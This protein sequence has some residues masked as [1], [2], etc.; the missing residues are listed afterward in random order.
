M[1]RKITIEENVLDKAIKWVAPVRAAR[2]FHARAMLALAGG[3]V[4]GSRTRRSLSTFTPHGTSADAALLPDLPDLR[5]RSRDLYRNSPLAGGAIKTNVTS[6]A[7]DGLTMKCAIDREYL[8]LSDDAAEQW[9]KD[10]ERLWCLWSE[11]KECDT[12]RTQP[13]G[14]MQGLVLGST[15]KNGDVF[16]VLPM[17]TPPR[18]AV[19]SQGD[20]DRGRPRYE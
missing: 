16:S 20:A 2:R 15:L 4:G 14:E 3:Y 18:L 11:S 10:C 17:I 12:T 8:G 7:G 19:R 6:V 13:F 5:A 9:E 1:A